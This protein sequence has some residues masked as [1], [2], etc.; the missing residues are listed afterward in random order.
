MASAI[1]TSLNSA[2]STS[3]SGPRGGIIAGSA[4]GASLLALLAL[5]GMVVYYRRR[6]SKKNALLASYRSLPRSALLADE[7]AIDLAAARPLTTRKMSAAPK[8]LRPRGIGTG[9]IFH[10]GVWPPPGVPSRLEDPLLA[11]G[12]VNLS[13]IVDDVMGRHDVE[14]GRSISTYTTQSD[15]PLLGDMSPERGGDAPATPQRVPAR[16]ADML[17]SHFSM[18]SDPSEITPLN[19]SER[20]ER[21]FSN[22]PPPPGPPTASSARPEM[23]RG[24]STRSAVSTTGSLS[25]DFPSRLGSL[26]VVNNSSPEIGQSL[27]GLDAHH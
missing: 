18:T 13:T 6:R 16:P 21:Q 19:L 9:S 23:A 10:E 4:I 11:G 15:V 20:H 2:P 17:R 7:D 3:S 26:V 24:Q 25:Y 5:C 27:S 8:L 22:D 14:H 12:T 1:T